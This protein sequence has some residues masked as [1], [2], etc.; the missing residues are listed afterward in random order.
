MIYLCQHSEK[1]Y[2]HWEKHKNEEPLPDTRPK[3]KYDLPGTVLHNQLMNL[4]FNIRGGCGCRDKINKM[5]A[6]GPEQCLER[7]DEICGW[8]EETASRGGYIEK[9]LVGLP[10]VNI[11]TKK[12]IHRLVSQAI[13]ESL[14]SK[15]EY[16][17]QKYS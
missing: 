16:I 11:L 1:Y 3:P 9:A 2:S 5:N 13:N 15:A 4:G 17:K 7:I 10:V 6:W 14:I 8:L 12:A